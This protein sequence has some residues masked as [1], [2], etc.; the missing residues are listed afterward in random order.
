MKHIR[1]FEE[2][3]KEDPDAEIRN[4]G[5][6]V[7]SA[8]SSKVKDNKDHFP[9]ND[10]KHGRNALAMVQKYDS[11]PKWY[12]GTLK[13]VKDAVIKAVHKKFPSIEISELDE[14]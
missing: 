14:D 1:L 12:D 8:E 7:F 2:F 13:E 9:I 4:R 10:L 5:D 11:V 3:G 6:V